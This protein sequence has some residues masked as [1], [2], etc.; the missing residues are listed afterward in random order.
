MCLKTAV[1]PL[2]YRR[3]FVLKVLSFC[4]INTVIRSQRSCRE[5]ICVAKTVLRDEDTSTEDF[6]FD[7]H[8]T[9][10][11][12]CVLQLYLLITQHIVLKFLSDST[13]NPEVGAQRS[14]RKS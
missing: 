12:L 3:A 11:V 6:N 13:R 9:H 1:R 10:V 2:E 7:Q 8:D 4:P 14:P 5:T